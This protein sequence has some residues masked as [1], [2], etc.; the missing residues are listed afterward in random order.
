MMRA[1]R[2]SLLTTL[3]ALVG[4]LVTIPIAAMAAVSV[5]Y[6]RFPPISSR[7][8]LN[9]LGP[10][11]LGVFSSIVAV[12]VAVALVTIGVAWWR[13]AWLVPLGGLAVTILLWHLGAALMQAPPLLT[14]G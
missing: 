8:D 11:S 12:A 13:R 1:D 5:A 9:L 7:D 6:A 4:Y 14:G 3:G 10:A 2:G